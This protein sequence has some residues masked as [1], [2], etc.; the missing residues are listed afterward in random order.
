MCVRGGVLA[1]CAGVGWVT[2]LGKEC[3]P[4]AVRFSCVHCVVPKC[5][6]GNCICGQMDAWEGYE[7]GRTMSRIKFT[8]RPGYCTLD[9][10][11]PSDTL[12]ATQGPL[13]WQSPCFGFAFDDGIPRDHTAPNDGRT[14]F[15]PEG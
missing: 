6:S 1:V 11:P 12:N 4:C 9:A 14:R 3:I 2:S 13:L 7:S 8:L 10:G 5:V 15:A